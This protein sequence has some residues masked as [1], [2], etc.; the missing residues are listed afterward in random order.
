MSIDHIALYT[1]DLERSRS[2]YECFFGGHSNSRYHN[3]NTGLQTYFLEF[4]GGTRLELMMRPDVSGNRPPVLH[5]GYIHIAFRADS[6]E[7]VDLLTR[8][9]M[10]AGYPIVSAPRI[11]GDGYYESCVL[12][13]D[14]NLVEIVG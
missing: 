9:L 11:T 4:E 6:R 14:G 7:A 12:D 10:E 2:F 8:R 3:P 5:P 1:Q 13:P